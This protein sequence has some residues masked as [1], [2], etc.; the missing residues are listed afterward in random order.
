MKIPAIAAATVLVLLGAGSAVAYRAGGQFDSFMRQ[1]QTLDPQVSTV[2]LGQ[3][4]V[5]RGLFSSTA[6]ARLEFPGMP[7][8]LNVPVQVQASQGPALDGSV[9]RVRMVMDL[10]TESALRDWMAAQNVHRSPF[11]CRLRFG[12][13]GHLDRLAVDVLPVHRS[14]KDMPAQARPLLLDWDGAQLRMSHKGSYTTG[15]SSSGTLQWSALKFS[16]DE[17]L[18]LK[19][20]VGAIRETFTEQGRMRNSS[21]TLEL[22]SEPTVVDG[23]LGQ[24]RIESLRM[25][26]TIAAHFEES[27]YADNPS[28]MPSG[29]AAFKNLDFA[30]AMSK[31]YEGRIALTGNVELPVPEAPR[32]QAA[33]A[34]MGAAEGRWL[35]SAQGALDLRISSSLLNLLEP[36]ARQALLRQGYFAEQ[37]EDLVSRVV[38]EPGRVTMNGK[39]L[40]A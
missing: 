27:G 29:R 31:P 19:G 1:A 17:P 3:V 15:G 28:G 20:Q 6:T 38:L 39:E 24:A 8:W 9:L 34:A 5:R 40:G 36:S 18:P 7:E 22:N 35:R 2:R 33:P 30:L 25:R 4:V 14:P 26:V 13:E 11:Q 10:E 21:S 32:A 12:L 23:P 16:M 37:Q